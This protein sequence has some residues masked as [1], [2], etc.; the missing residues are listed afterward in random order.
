VGF[1]VAVGIGVEFSTGVAVVGV[2][3]VVVVA[4]VALSETAFSLFPPLQ[5]I[6][7]QEAIIAKIV[8]ICLISIKVSPLDNMRL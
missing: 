7:R 2:A 1:G 3:V 4:I 6:I 8:R 5:E